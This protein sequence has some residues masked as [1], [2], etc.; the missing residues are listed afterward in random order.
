MKLKSDRDLFDKIQSDKVSDMQ[1][2]CHFIRTLEHRVPLRGGR[3][4]VEPFE[5]YGRKVLEQY[6]D[7]LCQSCRHRSQN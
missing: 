3:T 7:S 2:I 1:D 4:I 5:C 6:L